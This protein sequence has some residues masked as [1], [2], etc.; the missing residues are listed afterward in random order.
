MF[1]A[2]AVIADGPMVALL[3]T[4]GVIYMLEIG[5]AG[6]VSLLIAEEILPAETGGR[7]RH[8]PEYDYS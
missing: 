7:V 1:W 2:E 4:V 5:T 8:L 6:K 3:G